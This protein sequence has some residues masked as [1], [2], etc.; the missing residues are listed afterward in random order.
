MN[1]REKVEYLSTYQSIVAKIAGNLKEYE[2][3]L[4]IGS[5][6]TQMIQQDEGH[7]S[8]GEKRIE[9]AAIMMAEISK[10]ID[11]ETKKAIRDRDEILACIAKKSRNKRYSELL[12]MRF[13][14]VMS[15]YEIAEAINKNL[16]TEQRAM[17]KAID[18]LDI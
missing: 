5:K 13:V 14:K 2:R 1:F 6:C 9:N 15:N 4:V 11:S 16:R 8:G 3:W 12:E 10:A 17:H 18:S 7:G